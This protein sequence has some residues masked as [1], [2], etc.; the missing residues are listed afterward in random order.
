MGFLAYLDVKA[1]LAVRKAHANAIRLYSTSEV[2]RMLKIHK[3]VILRWLATGEVQHPAHYC[4]HNGINFLWDE[5]DLK[6]IRSLAA[7]KKR[8][9]LSPYRRSSALP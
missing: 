5:R 1:P 2:A 6:A 3:M 7:W 4:F 9:R 8:K